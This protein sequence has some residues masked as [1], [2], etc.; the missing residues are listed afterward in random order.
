MKTIKNIYILIS[1]VVLITALVLGTSYLV[2]G[3]ITGLIFL[4]PVLFLLVFYYILAPRNIFVT[5]G[6]E[7]RIM[8]IM[9]GKEF[10]GK[11]ILPSKT[12]YVDK[13]D[14]YKI[15]S[16]E[17]LSPDSTNKV[18]KKLKQYNI[19]GM[20]WIGVYPWLSIYER[21]QQW[22]EWKSTPTGREIQFRDEMTPFLIAKPFEYAMLLV[23]AEDK[24][25]VPLNIY[26]TVILMPTNAVIPIFGNN[27]AY[28]QVQTLCLGEALLLVKEK[29]FANLGAGNITI[30]IT[31]DEFSKVICELNNKI[32]GRFKED[33]SDSTKKIEVGLEEALGYKILDAKLNSIEIAGTH[34]EEILKAT[35]AKYV[36]H[37]NAQAVIETAEGEKQ[38]DI[39]RSEGTKA[40]LKVQREYLDDISKID[41]AMGV[42]KRKATPGLTTLVEEG[43]ANINL[44]GKS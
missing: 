32:P 7:N 33:P 35:T 6:R 34:K 2:L 4:L 30:D 41:G 20:Y 24:N 25:G 14:K 16:F 8:H 21:H 1:I 19:L 43:A 13:E 26:F 23:E 37:E 18:K 9:V 44:G 28:G 39:L 17:D 10:S 38:S 3:I 27:D 11:V 29:T 22:L 15:K 5:L 12:L 31:K 40:K 42:E 36:A